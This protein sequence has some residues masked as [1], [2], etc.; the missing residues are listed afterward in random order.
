MVVRPP[1]NA[2]GTEA[3]LIGEIADA[4]MLVVRAGSTR[5]RALEEALG[6]LEQ[7]QLAGVF[8]NCLEQRGATSYYYAYGE[9]EAP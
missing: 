5:R 9:E 4:C 8:V 6:Y 3:Q 7:T 2:D 1:V